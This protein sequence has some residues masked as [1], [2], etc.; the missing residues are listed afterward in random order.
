MATTST[1][2]ARKILTKRAEIL[3]NEE[4]LKRTRQKN[5]ALKAELKTMRKAKA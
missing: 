3:R 2:K 1:E 4:L 5:A